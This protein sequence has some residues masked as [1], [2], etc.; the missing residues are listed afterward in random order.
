M[1]NKKYNIL[2]G[3]TW[4]VLSVALAILLQYIKQTKGG[5]YNWADSFPVWIGGVI[6]GS[7]SGF[8]FL[9]IEFLIFKKIKINKIVKLL[10]MCFTLLLI[11]L[12]VSSKVFYNW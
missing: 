5:N 4:F 3:F 8:V 2:Y 6:K 9:T 1:K 11:I 10:I 12:L 7:I